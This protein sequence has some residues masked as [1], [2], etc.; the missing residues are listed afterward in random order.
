[1]LSINCSFGGNDELFGGPGEVDY[2]I[3]GSFD[4]LIDGGDGMDLAFG[5]HASITLSVSVSHMLKHAITTDANCTGGGDNIT[6]G[7]GDDL[8]RFFVMLRTTLSIF[9]Y[10]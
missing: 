3:G 9:W 7:S 10:G 6:L 8:V 4:D 1:M 2:I 5:D